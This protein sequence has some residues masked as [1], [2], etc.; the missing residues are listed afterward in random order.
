MTL[1]FLLLL[2]PLL[3]SACGAL[4]TPDPP[5]STPTTA[6]TPTDPPTH[7]PLPP[8][9]TLTPRPTWTL[10]PSP[11]P[12]ASFT[13]LPAPFRYVF[14]LRVIYSYSDGVTGHG[15]PAIDLFAPAKT[16]FQ[17]VTDGVVDFI[18]YTDKWNP[19]KPDPGQRGGISVAIVGDD[20]VRYY[21]AHLSA[22]A[23]GLEVGQRVTAGQLL[24]YVGRTGDAFDT[25]PHLH[26]GISRP[27]FPDDWQARRGQVDPYP[28]L[29]AWQS[30]I[31]LTP[32]L[33]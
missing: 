15:Y 4:P 13:P 24:G 21:G 33:P 22:V 8:T 28:Y 10:P 12:I 23:Q 27:T 32:V 29:Q 2:C 31:M 30:G 25:E 3:L 17:A 19:K 14:P 26:F 20:G 18:S 7:T 16:K 11:T 9:A 5:T 1:R 6:A